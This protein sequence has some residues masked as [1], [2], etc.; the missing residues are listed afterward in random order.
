MSARTRLVG[1]YGGAALA[2]NF[3]GGVLAAGHFSAG[4]FAAGTFAIGIFSIGIFAIGVFSLGL[5]SI[6]EFGLG[7]WVMAVRRKT[8]PDGARA[9][10]PLAGRPRETA[11]T[12]R[13]TAAHVA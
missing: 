12:K 2:I 4:I 6:G 8:L 11:P 1:T 13:G 9:V 7:F 10:R 5:F 3:A